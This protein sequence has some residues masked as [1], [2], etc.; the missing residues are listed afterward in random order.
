M[1]ERAHSIHYRIARYFLDNHRLTILSLLFLVLAGVFSVFALKTTGFPNAEVKLVLVQ[2]VYPGASADTM[3]DVVTRPLEG[4]IKNIDGI[5]SY[6][7]RSLDSF[8]SISIQ[9]SQ[10]ADT[11]SVRSQID[12]AVRAATLP[13][14]VTPKV[15]SPDFSNADLVLSIAGNTLEEAYTITD[16][17][18]HDIQALA[19]TRSVEQAVALEKHYTVLV[20]SDRAA[21]RGVTL[22]AVRAY[23]STIGERIPVASGVAIEDEQRS[24]ITALPATTTESVLNA[25][26]TSVSGTPVRLGDIATVETR[27]A[28]E[29]GA[30]PVIGLRDHEGRTAVVP[31]VTLLISTVKDIDQSAYVSAVHDIVRDAGVTLMQ[32]GEENLEAP[33]PWVV[34]N[35]ASNTFNQDQVSEVIGGLIGAP[36]ETDAWWRNVGWVL[37]GIQLVFLVMLAFV[38]WRAAVIAAAAIPLSLV[39]STIY[40][41]LIGEQLN[42]LV[43]FSLVLV[44][45]LVVDP[46]LVILES[47]QRKIDTGL[48]GKEAA[49]AAMEDVGRGLFMATL[50]NIIVFLPFGLI[51]GFLGKF[52]IFIPYTII[53]ATI[54][55]Y[56]VPVVFLA[57]MG[58]LFLRKSK[59]S[60]A[61]EEKN[62]WSIARWIIRANERILQSSVWT[63]FAFI[64]VAF[65]IPMAVAGVLF[66]TGSIKVV[67]FAS[68]T[69]PDFLNISGEY[70]PSTQ[71]SQRNADLR[72][73]VSTTISQEGV[74]QVYPLTQGLFYFVNLEKAT[75]R[76]ITAPDIAH[77]IQE[78]IVDLPSLFDIKTRINQVG[79][80][81]AD[82]EIA[83][84]VDIESQED[85]QALA[86]DIG[87][88]LS[89]VCMT[90]EK[91]IQVGTE[92][93]CGQGTAL[94]TRVDDGFTGKTQ[95]VVRVTVDAQALARFQLT[96][97]NA[98]V[99]IVVNQLLRSAFLMPDDAAVDTLTI[100]GEERVVMLAQTQDAPR[101]LEDIRNL[102][103]FAGPAGIVRLR[104]VA[105]VESVESPSSIVSVNG[106]TLAVVQGRLVE[107]YADQQT[108]AQ[109]TNAVVDYYRTGEGKSVL[110][111][112]ELAPEDI[113]SYSEGSSAET[114]QSFKD[115]FLTLIFA[116]IF[117]YIVLAVFFESFTQPVVILFTI[118]LTFLGIFPGLAW[119]VGGQFG[120]LEI[121]GL[122]ILVGVV[123][124]VAI[125]LIDAARQKIDEEGWS[126]IKAISYAAGVRFR[127]ILLTKFTAIASLAPLAVFSEIYRSI[128][129]LIMFGLLTSGFTSLFTTP[130]LFIFFRWLSK[131]FWAA[132]WWGKVVILLFF[133]IAVLVMW[134][135]ERKSKK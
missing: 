13:D 116:I 75:E 40:I 42:T 15:F 44:I 104:D 130:V 101:N 47:I 128:A 120:F 18:T 68:S 27:Y 95:H 114:V 35:Y 98:P 102:V 5:E 10:N 56:I 54:G 25:Q 86:Q 66:A 105:T 32:P 29:G 133:P 9:V 53:P 107:E 73:I 129:I 28:F 127:P 45:G 39:F 51:S 41:Y 58:G 113:D 135:R 89:S 37:G 30:E 59:Q 72:E 99:S 91:T 14:D 85:A 122:I 62:L 17:L 119:F 77:A 76:D 123:E 60:T 65:S 67:Q 1:K 69:D 6:N 124:N 79:P 115:L 100:D 80:P 78:E 94:I 12:S 90:V 71:Q 38:S 96:V 121:I 3:L 118:P 21:A 2:A 52:F 24:I 43:L 16:R 126:D 61:D 48:K 11:S 103:L 109:V 46:A 4:A 92:S 82:Y 22:S 57:W 64:V 106:Q 36:L 97:P 34:Q 49:L 70:R 31:A 87:K 88:T 74:E 93:G 83:L 108:A 19:D 7:S 134:M 20:D 112:Y 81:L 63:R 84:A 111:A 110:E 132:P 117:T 23:L 125:F 50:T 55:S 26:V 8:S 131:H 33:Y